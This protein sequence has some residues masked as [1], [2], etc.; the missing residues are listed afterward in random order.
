[1]HAADADLAHVAVVVQRADLQLQRRFRVVLTHR[2]VLDHGVKDGAHVADLLQFLDVIGV[3]RV[4]FESGRVDHRE[5]ELVFGG[6]KLV[7]EIERLIDDPFRTSARTVHLVD[8]DDGLQAG[9]ER[10]AGHKARLR[11]RAVHGVHEQKHAVHHG[12]DALHLTAK[13]RVPRG[14]DD[15]DVH[16]FVFHGAVLRENRDAA[17]LF[18][19]AAVHHAL[20]D[21]LIAAERA[22]ALQ[23][24]VNHGRLAVVNV[25]NDCNIAN[26]SC[27]FNFLKLSRFQS[28]RII[29]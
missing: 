10:L 24:L 13:V 5:V 23:E 17:F 18:D 22:R 7:K 12:E 6:A 29:L 3:A 27:H 20:V 11:H 25:S 14:V 28:G 19:V 15:V 26:S 1:M 8:D 4:A 16:A 9:G 21:L 2:N